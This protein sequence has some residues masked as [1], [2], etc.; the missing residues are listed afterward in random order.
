LPRRLSKSGFYHIVFRG[1]NHCHLFEEREDYERLLKTLAVIKAELPIDLYAYCLMSNHAHLL[2]QESKPGDITHAMRRLLVSYACWFNKKYQRSGSLISNR[3]KSE[4]VE[5][6][7]Y[8]LILARYI[9]QNPL[10]AGVTR[11]IADYPWSSYRDYTSSSTTLS[12]IEL[13]LDMF[14]E[15]REEAVRQFIEFHKALDDVD[16][17]LPDRRRRSEEQARAGMIEA[18]GGIEPS[19]VIGLD[20]QERNLL[21]MALR[22]GGFSIRQI[23]RVT[24]I[25][26]GVIARM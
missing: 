11:F 24:G 5:D 6:N 23:E 18:L 9:H 13:M 14:S 8:L 1:V 19:A 15:N 20:K 10:K 16:R 3:Y 26:R 7:S 17:S 4:C 22:K 12:D 25:S 21:L 2:I